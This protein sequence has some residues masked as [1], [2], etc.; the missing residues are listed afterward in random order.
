MNKVIFEGREYDDIPPDS[1][2]VLHA[3]NIHTFRYYAEDGLWM[4]SDLCASHFGMKKFFSGGY[5]EV[6]SMVIYPQ[7]HHKHMSLYDRVLSGENFVSDNLRSVD[8]I[9]YYRVSL[10]VLEKDDDGRPLIIGGIFEDF[11]EHLKSM[12][13]MNMLSDDFSSVFQVDFNKEHIEPCRISEFINDA[14]G[15]LIASDPP[16]SDLLSY[17]IENDVLE[18]DREEMR[19]VTSYENLSRVLTGKKVYRHDFRVVRNGIPGYVRMKVVNM[20]EDQKA[21]TRA[22]IGFINIDHDRQEE[23]LRLA[24][25]DQVTGGYNY[26]FYNEKLK[27]QSVKGF[28]AALDIHSFKIINSICGIE[29]GDQVL[30]GVSRMLEVILNGRGFFGHINA[31][32]FICFLE[33]ED[34]ARAAAILDEITEKFETLSFGDIPKIT[35]YFGVTSWK[36]GDR[37]QIVFSEANSAKSRIRHSLDIN[38]SFYRDEDIAAAIEEKRI[39][40]SF[41]SALKDDEF[42]IWYQPKYDTS[43]SILMGAEALVRWRKKDGSLVLPNSFIPVFEKNGMI[44]YLDR[45]VFSKVCKSQSSWKERFGGTVPV[46]VNLSRSSLY[47]DDLVDEYTSIIK[48]TGIDPD[49]VPIE[50]TETATVDGSNITSMTD[51][52]HKAGF[53]LQIDDFGKGYSSLSSINTVKFD[54]I[55][56]DKSLIDYIGENRGDCLIRHTVA[57]AKDLGISVTAEGVETEEQVRFLKSIECD[58][59]QGYYFSKPLPEAYFVDMLSDRYISAEAY[60]N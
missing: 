26:N 30:A 2:K 37:S 50:I 15:D 14:F 7:D 1:Q 56:L 20:S 25:F 35:P 48:G 5:R 4:A 58:C 10:S 19:R 34:E 22:V 28:V 45:Y 32:H 46:T 41:E 31:D 47:Y 12:E 27:H 55:K 54:T 52:F 33:V 39:E 44:K 13:L 57:L 40:D 59:V 16:F 29:K 8:G 42:E 36:P 6:Q 43:G 18:D 21:L 11:D 38:Y 17:Y 24:Y 60:I 23:W 3:A 49:M 9:S 53:Q 51:R